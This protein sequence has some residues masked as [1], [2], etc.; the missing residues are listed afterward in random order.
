MPTNLYLAGKKTA[1]KQINKWTND[2]LGELQQGVCPFPS[3][4][5]CTESS[6]SL[7]L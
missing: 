7:P 5:H 1:E 4:K 2:T 6:S 3:Q